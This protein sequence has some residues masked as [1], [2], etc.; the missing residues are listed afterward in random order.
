MKT[1]IAAATLALMA[2]TATAAN[3]YIEDKT[4]QSFDVCVLQAGF[5]LAS[6]RENGVTPIRIVDSAADQTF[7]YKVSVNGTT[8]F[9]SCTGKSYKVWIMN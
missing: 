7:L 9:V 3:T 2:T 6:I 4:M 5:T 8:G 1:L